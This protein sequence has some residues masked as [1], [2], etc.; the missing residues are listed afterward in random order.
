MAASALGL[1][2]QTVKAKDDSAATTT[3]NGEDGHSWVAPRELLAGLASPSGSEEFFVTQAATG[4]E[5][6]VAL[7]ERTGRLAVLGGV[8]H[9]ALGLSLSPEEMS[10]LGYG[11]TQ[12]PDSDDERDM[13]LSAPVALEPSEAWTGWASQDYGG[14]D[15]EA[16]RR[17][18]KKVVDVCA[19]GQ[20]TI[21]RTD[22]GQA[23]SFG[24]PS[25][26]ALGRPVSET[27][28]EAGMLGNWSIPG[29]VAV[30]TDLSVA[31]VSCGG[32]HA[33]LQLV[34]VWR[35]QKGEQEVEE[36][37]VMDAGLWSV[38]WNE[39]GQLGLGNTRDTDVPA[40][41]PLATVGEDVAENEDGEISI[42]APRRI[43]A[44]AGAYAHTLW[45][46]VEP[47]TDGGQDKTVLYA[48]GLND[49]GELGV[50]RN[51]AQ[52]LEDI[53]EDLEE[54]HRDG[55]TAAAGETTKSDFRTSLTP[56][57][58]STSSV[59]PADAGFKHTVVLG[60]RDPTG[61]GWARVLSCGDD[62]WG[63]L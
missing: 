50:G 10:R 5:H 39:Y 43:R 3:E 13:V 53:A 31:G 26:G 1:N 57:S 2:S 4:H 17:K 14:S 62:A 25:F 32:D 23:W 37:A 21:V 52:D 49:H 35:V 9:G 12:G 44:V 41:V 11:L 22:D 59:G 61:R 8:R 40:L 55:D 45:M 56:V 24:T 28:S 36:E 63:Q 34:H 60:D 15:D 27:D 7:D 48:S 20:F 19:G 51:V 30:P 33:V 18:E 47:A 6:T 29:P 46:S 42:G 58:I 38:G 54:Q 16:R